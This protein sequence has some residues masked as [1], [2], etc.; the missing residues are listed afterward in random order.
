MEGI[1]FFHPDS[2]RLNPHLPQVVLTG[3]KLFNQDVSIADPSQETQDAYVLP[4][5]ISGVE[6]IRLPYHQNFLSFE[7][8]ALEYTNPAQNQYAYR[9]VGVDKEWVYSAEPGDLLTIQIWAQETMYSK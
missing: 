1:T 6:Q 9:L 8:A 2:L 7:F 4:M 3:F 5:E